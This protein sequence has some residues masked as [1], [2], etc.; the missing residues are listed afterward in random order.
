MYINI[1]SK[2]VNNDRYA[3]VHIYFNFTGKLE[4][5]FPSTLILDFQFFLMKIRKYIEK[6]I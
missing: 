4:N 5:V 3:K 2:Y 6:I 1:R